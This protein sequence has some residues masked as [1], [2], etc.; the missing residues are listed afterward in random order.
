MTKEIIEAQK[1]G[2]GDDAFIVGR[3]INHEGKQRNMPTV[4]FGPVAQMPD[5]PI[6]VGG[7][8]QESFLVEARS[9]G[10]FSGS[11]VFWQV[12]PFQGG[13]YRGSTNL[14]LGPLLLGVEWG[15]IHTWAPLCDALGRPLGDGPPFDRQVEQNAGMTCVVPAWKLAELLNGGDVLRKRKEIEQQVLETEKRTP[16]GPPTVTQSNASASAGRRA[17]RAATDENP[18]HLED[19]TSLLNAAAKTKPQDD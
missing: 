6:R 19:F 12:L 15:Y 5:E 3:F 18:R 4:R 10:G 16:P 1:V 13:P 17:A 14:G 8:D 7:F 2:P 11:P 9:I